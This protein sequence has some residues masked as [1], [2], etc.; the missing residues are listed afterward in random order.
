[1]ATSSPSSRSA[2]AAQRGSCPLCDG[3]AIK[4]YRRLTRHYAG[5]QFDLRLGQCLDCRFVFLRNDLIIDYD[6]DYLRRENV[7]TAADPLARFRAAERLAHIARWVPPSA[8]HS[9][10]DIGVGDGLLLSLAE[11]AG[12]AA[13]GLDVNAEGVALARQMY[14]LRATISLEPLQTAFPQER[15]S[16]I[17]M[18][19]VIEHIAEPRPLLEWCRAR[20]G[21]SG[22]LVIQ[23]GNIDSIAS[24]LKADAWDYYR[25]V[26]V[27]YFSAATL[28]GAVQRAGFRVVHRATV[29]WRS[30]SVVKQAWHL[31]R[32][33]RP[34]Q[35]LQFFLLHFTAL[36]PGFRRAI[37]VSAM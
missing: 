30:R 12:Y 31:A 11:E 19:E 7:L 23:T 34:G 33:G 6:G 32:H 22:L 2:I 18:N 3:R 36:W 35:A 13:F 20:L 1:M 29:D 15:F 37:I 24:R 10:L 16:V 8:G 25:P 27:S 4:P 26:H 17:H 28:T 14:Q 5:Q 21:P 9:F